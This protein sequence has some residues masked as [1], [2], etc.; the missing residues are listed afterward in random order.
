MRPLRFRQ[1][2]SLTIPPQLL[3]SSLSWSRRSALCP[4]SALT[5][6]LSGAADGTVEFDDG[7]GDGREGVGAT[8]LGIRTVVTASVP[9]LVACGAIPLYLDLVHGVLIERHGGNPM[10]L[11]RV[12][13]HLLNGS[14]RGRAIGG[15][16][17]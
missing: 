16:P 8:A 2:L 1:S 5:E 14:Y 3:I 17:L 6:E 15:F 7:A 9:A 12:A 10:G 13:R 11:D 4:T